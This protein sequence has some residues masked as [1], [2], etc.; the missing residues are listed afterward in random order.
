MMLNSG[1]MT[2]DDLTPFGE[3][4]RERLSGGCDEHWI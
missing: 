3:E 1:V 2:K 4:L